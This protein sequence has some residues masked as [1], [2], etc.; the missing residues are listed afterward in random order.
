V[1][2]SD[3]YGKDVLSGDW[4]APRRGRATE[5]AA[6]MGMV[7][8]EVTTDFCGAVVRLDRDLGTVELEDRFGKRRTFPLGPGFLLEGRPVILRAPARRGPARP[9]RTASG[10]RAVAGVQAR[11]ARESRI[12]VEGRHDAELVE[13]V[14]GDDLR[15]EGVVVEH[16]DGVDD[17]PAVVRDFSP[18]PGR[19]VGVLV[20]HLVPGSKESRI[21]QS[22]A[23]GRDG[24]HVLVVGHPYVDIWQ[25]V[26][27]ARLGLSAWPT[28]PR[29]V[30]WKQGVC[31]SL[32]WP[33]RS[34]ADIARAWRQ[35][36][37]RVRS[38]AD[39]EPA[40][41]GRVEELIDFVTAD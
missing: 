28:I 27:P 25:A 1:S 10:S 35:I 20:D 3:R 34:Q 4:R 30:P 9:T 39:L 11:V 38:Y 36:L 26:K 16:L 13:K 19:R 21:A 22:V 15:I 12:F 40:L 5:A 14:W 8:E 32:G 41:L 23:R 17:L 6:E 18:G 7:L 33:H 2:A 37:G 31:Q 29:S 24:A